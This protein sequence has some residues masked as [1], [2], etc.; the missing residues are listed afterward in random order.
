MPLAFSAFAAGDP[1][2]I[3][4]T[5]PV[6]FRD[7]L[8]QS[9]EPS[10]V[11]VNSTTVAEFLAMPG[12]W[13]TAEELHAE[14][15]RGSIDDTTCLHLAAYKDAWLGMTNQ[16]QHD[17]ADCGADSSNERYMVHDHVWATAG[18]CPFGLLCI[19]C[20]EKRLRRRL[21]AA[22]FLDVG[23]N[24]DPGYQRSARLIDRLAATI[25]ATFRP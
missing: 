15:H 5:A 19:G 3:E 21:V 10:T 4:G 17:C 11:F 2:L 18:M 22:D 1:Q 23:L 14:L 12:T 16:W 20:I 6:S 7:W 24:H 13:T 9:H 8:G 25:P